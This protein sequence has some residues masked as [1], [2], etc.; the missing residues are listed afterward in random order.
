MAAAIRLLVTGFGPFPGMRRNPSARLARDLGRSRRLRRLGLDVA[1]RVFETRYD[2]LLRDLPSAL[3]ETAP[4]VVLMLGVVGRAKALR[5]EVRGTNCMR[6]LAPDAAGSIPSAP[7]EFDRPFALRSRA[8]AGPCITALA[9]SGLAARR[10]IHAGRYLCNASYYEAL[11]WAGPQGPLVLFVHV[12]R[13][14]PEPGTVP[15]TRSGQGRPS[16]AAMQHGL[17][18]LAVLLARQ[19]HPA[20]S[21]GQKVAQSAG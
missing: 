17:T 20:F 18:E 9:R 11:Q 3:A 10:S 12:P 1:A 6:C 13:P 14:A 2:S 7:P 19:A 8:P 5:V 16:L 4:H 21:P 15:R